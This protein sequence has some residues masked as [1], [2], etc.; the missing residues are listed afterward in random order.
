MSGVISARTLMLAPGGGGPWMATVRRTS[1]S[2]V[3][4][5]TTAGR[6]AR[7][8][9]HGGRARI[10]RP[11]PAGPGRIRRPLS[12][13]PIRTVPAAPIPI[14]LT[15]RT[16]RTRLTRLIRLIRLTPRSQPDRAASAE[17][18]STRPRLDRLWWPCCSPGCS[19]AWLVAP[20]SAARSA[21]WPAFAP[22]GANARP[23][24]SRP[25]CRRGRWLTPRPR[26]NGPYRSPPSPRALCRRL[27]RSP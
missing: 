5:P 10:R 17:S 27:S 14:R 25:R 1:R 24:G 4:R 6:P 16:R 26:A 12:L 22:Y 18:R 2:G 9:G 19:A 11:L 8:R 7:R 13:P 15:R 20:S 23:R 3:N 21:A